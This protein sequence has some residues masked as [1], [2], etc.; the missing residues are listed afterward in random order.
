M[1]IHCRKAKL[2]GGRRL[3]RVKKLDKRHSSILRNRL[4][5]FL[6]LVSFLQIDF[7]TYGRL[8]SFALLI[9]EALALLLRLPHRVIWS[10]WNNQSGAC[11]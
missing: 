4:V 9:K 7:S 5:A 11:Q 8:P 10:P 3:E 2:P 1:K 6:H